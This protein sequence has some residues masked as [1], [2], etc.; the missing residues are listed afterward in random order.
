MCVVPSDF[1]QETVLESESLISD[2]S[3]CA[4]LFVCV[5]GASKW[6]WRAGYVCVR[7]LFSVCTGV[8]VF[9][10]HCI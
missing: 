5:S 2:S 3:V 1:C 9:Y 4:C 10:I 8:Y 7:A 6:V